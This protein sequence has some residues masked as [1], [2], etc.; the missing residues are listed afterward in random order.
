MNRVHIVTDSTACLPPHIA[1]ELDIAVV[2]AFINFGTE[3]YRDGVDLTAEEFYA[4][5]AASPTLPTTAVPPPGVFEETYRRL[6]QTSRHIVSIHLPAKLSGMLN[7][8]M[9]AA[10]AL[11]DLD[12]VLIDSQT[13]SM[14]LGWLTII[15]ARAARE[16]CSADEVTARV[17]ATIPRSRLL[18]VLDTL[19][20][21]RRGGRVSLPQ[22]FLGTLLD[23]KPILEVRDGS[24]HPLEKARTRRRAIERVVELATAMAPFDELAALHTNAPERAEEVKSR[25]AAFHPPDRILVV[26]AGPILG[27]HVGPGGVGMAGVVAGKV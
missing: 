25:L 9:T 22:A 12:I 27:T 4:K 18:A 5:L 14:A 2:P 15:A 13:L 11:P 1:S 20:Y 21:L 24:I 8:A 26:E 3:S 23:I 10:R 7:S 17:N 16:G 6:G 19:E